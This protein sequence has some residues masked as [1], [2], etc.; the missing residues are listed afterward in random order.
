MQQHAEIGGPVEPRFGARVKHVLDVGDEVGKNMRAAA[1]EAFQLEDA[2]TRRLE[3]QIVFEE[4]GVDR[5]FEEE[6]I[7]LHIAVSVDDRDTF[8]VEGSG[9]WI[10][11]VNRKQRLPAHVAVDRERVRN[12]SRT[13]EEGIDGKGRISRCRKREIALTDG[14]RD[15]EEIPRLAV[16]Q[17][18]QTLV[19][20]ALEIDEGDV[21][22]L[23]SICG[24]VH[25]AAAL[26]DED[27]AAAAE[28]T[29][30][31]RLEGAP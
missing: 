12:R 4:T 31:P 10:G 19:L 17:R 20:E 6:R 27:V 15:L 1:R 29:G 30:Q 25:R 13:A 22:D 14:I 2:A 18:N 16:L 24:G 9:P 11:V 3:E 21:L 5:L 8:L 23:P 26:V 7:I 28:I